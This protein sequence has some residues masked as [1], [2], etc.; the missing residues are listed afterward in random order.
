MPDEGSDLIVYSPDGEAKLAVEVKR[1]PTADDAWAIKFRRN[2]M[3]H[4][5]ISQT[6]Y[7]LLAMIENL[8]LWTPGSPIDQDSVDYKAKTAD[9]LGRFIDPDD[10]VSITGSGLEL[11]VSSWLKT[12]VDSEVSK[13]SAP[14]LDWVLDSG[15]YETIKNGSVELEYQR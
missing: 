14:E 8:Y 9:V 10:L 13:E 7:F 1:V 3:A 12:L 2:L 4:S 5:A 15:L 6:P 11:L